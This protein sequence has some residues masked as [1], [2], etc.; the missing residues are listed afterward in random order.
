MSAT[1]RRLVRKQVCDC[2]RLAWAIATTIR[3]R[4]DGIRFDAVRGPPGAIG[5][6]TLPIFYYPQSNRDT[7]TNGGS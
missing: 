2:P 6:L 7:A 3:V 5:G 1:A 4:Q